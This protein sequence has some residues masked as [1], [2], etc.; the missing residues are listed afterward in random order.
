MVRQPL[1][2]IPSLQEIRV[3]FV[4]ND[5]MMTELL[6]FILESAKAEII[7]ANSIHTALSQLSEQ[8]VDVVICSIQPPDMHGFELAHAIRSRSE[9]SINQL[10]AIAAATTVSSYS[11]AIA[12]RLVTN[13][14]FNQFIPLPTPPEKIVNA[15]L[16]LTE[17][18]R[19]LRKTQASSPGQ[20]DRFLP[21]LPPLQ[22]FVVPTSYPYSEWVQRTTPI[23]RRSE[24]GHS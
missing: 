22:T 21:P 18:P 11:Q 19:P 7:E 3:L 16:E 13:A 9:K 1:E 24:V 5:R 6:L 12:E 17:K 15:V 14:G 23:L 8:A 2:N 4:E 10:P 20:G